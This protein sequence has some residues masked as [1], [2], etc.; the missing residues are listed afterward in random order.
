MTTPTESTSNLEHH[1]PFTHDV[2][3]K[4]IEHAKANKG[5]YEIDN[6]MEQEKA[7]G[8]EYVAPQPIKIVKK[9]MGGSIGRHP[10]Y[11][12]DDFHAFPERNVAAQRHLALRRGDD[13]DKVQSRAKKSVPVHKSMDTMR[14]EMM[15]K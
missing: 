15:R 2:N 10:G 11:E 4:H 12:D 14:L 13:E 5:E 7:R 6:P 9:A 1:T 8:K 3:A